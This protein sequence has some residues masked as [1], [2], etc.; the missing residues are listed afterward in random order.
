[1]MGAPSLSPATKVKQD[2]RTQMRSALGRLFGNACDPLF[3]AKITSEEALKRITEDLKGRV[4][5][6]E[7]LY[8][9]SRLLENDTASL[10][11]ILRATILL[12]PPALRY[13]DI[14]RVRLALNELDIQTV[15]FIPIYPKLTNDIRIQGIK[16]GQLEIAYIEDRLEDK[17]NVF[18]DGEKRLAKSVAERI[19]NVAERFQ[20]RQSLVRSE[21]KFRVLVEN[22]LTGLLI[23]RNCNIV[24][25]NPQAERSFVSLF[26]AFTER[27]FSAV[28]P[29]DLERVKFSFEETMSG[30]FPSAELI[31]RYQLEEKKRASNQ[32]DW[33]D[34]RMALFEDDEGE[35]VL[36]H[37]MDVTNTKRAEQLLA[38]QDKLAAL[39]HVAAGIAHEIR[40]PLSGINI[41]LNTLGKMLDRD[42]NR[43]KSNQILESMKAASGKI[44]SIIK[45]VMDFARPSEPK[46]DWINLNKPFKEAIALSAVTLRKEGIE[47][48][49]RLE[50]A[51]PDYRADQQMLEQVMLNLIVNAA[52]A[53]KGCIGRKIIEVSSFI[54]QDC[55][56]L[57][58]ADSGPGIPPEIVDKV[59]DPFFSTKTNG[60]GIGLSLSHRI[61]TDHGGTLGVGESKWGGAEFR[62]KFPLSKGD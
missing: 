48:I 15:D 33:V 45:R 35:A 14:A 3:E 23:I 42:Q 28:H 5:E 51:L 6:L 2:L 40:N 19:G 9:I 58:V 57:T 38:H 12:I 27:D 62:V 55:V 52:E 49:E 37:L 24:F 46:L 61:V 8:S 18:L 10:D 56:V 13:P 4:K 34:C 53:M 1:M 31:F 44:E 32:W 29:S 30:D 11:Q 47:V 54:G 17:G 16:R 26:R 60:T 25:Y 20:F 7:C 39:G 50:G 36:L 59:F 43:E 21:R 22:L 41:Y